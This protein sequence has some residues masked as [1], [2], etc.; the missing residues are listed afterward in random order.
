MRG[1]WSPL[2]VRSVIY[3]CPALEGESGKL[4][5]NKSTLPNRREN[6]L[7]G[8][9][10]HMCR[11]SPRRPFDYK[12]NPRP[13]TTPVLTSVS[14]AFPIAGEAVLLLQT[15]GCGF[16]NSCHVTW[17]QNLMGTGEELNRGPASLTTFS[18]G[19]TDLN[20]KSLQTSGLRGGGGGGGVAWACPG[21]T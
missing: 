11:K 13:Q 21:A 20:G 12:C 19:F 1:D 4:E 7:K 9:S 3:Y 6:Q 10:R 18:A 5:N 8:S 15:H 17:F 14:S 2:P 16:A